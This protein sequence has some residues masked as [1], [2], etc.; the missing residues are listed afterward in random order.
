MTINDDDLRMLDDWR[1]GCIAEADFAT[2]QRRLSKDAGLRGELRA[3]ADLEEGLTTLAWQPIAIVPVSPLQDDVLSLRERTTFLSC[4]ENRRGLLR[5]WFPWTIAAVATVF[6]VLGW[7]PN[8]DAPPP[9]AARPVTAL[10]VDEAGA[11]F[12]RQRQPGEV[13]FDPGSYELRAGTV[14]LRFANGADLVV[15]GPA[16][17]NIRDEFHTQLA[18]G[19]VRAIVPPTARGFTLET[20]EVDYEDIGT[21]FGL[22]V[23]ASTGVSSMHVFDGQVNLHRAGAT[24]LIKSVFE[25]D[26]V[27]CRDGRVDAAADLNLDQFPSPDEIGFLRW[28]SLHQ[29]MLS[30]PSLIAWF[31]FTRADNASILT[32]AQRAHGLPDGRIAGAQWTTGRWAGKQA[33]LFDRDSDFAEFEIP[34]EFQELSI[35]AWL[36][37]DRFDWEM[38]AICNSNGSDSGDVHFQMTR[39]GL[40]RGGVLGSDRVNFRWVGNPVPLA[41]WV[42]V[43]SVLSIPQRRS[44]IYVNGEPVWEYDFKSNAGVLILPGHCRLGNWLQEGVKYGTSPRALRG[45]IDEVAIWNRALSQTEVLSQTEKGCPSLLWSR[46]NPP[47]RTPMPIPNS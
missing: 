31:P 19:R 14:H 47:L 22:S 4:K 33:L 41:K 13:R 5:R 8:P 38:N 11:E 46:E 20:K 21:E 34:G 15:Q 27:Q 37:V 17:F 44:V 39:H 26:G 23:D 7:I 45:V 25:G 32:N 35:A 9:N 42:Y 10:L 6:A 29:E 3:L 28:K 43:V 40:P 16:R 36:K 1:S 30:D 12:A 18:S 24:G 2:L